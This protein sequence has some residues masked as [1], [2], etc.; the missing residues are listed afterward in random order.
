MMGSLCLKELKKSMMKHLFTYG[1]VGLAEIESVNITQT[2][3]GIIP[4]SWKVS[5][6]EEISHLRSGGTPP[7]IN[8]NYF[9]GVSHG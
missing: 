2:E 3:I 1:P 9:K 7:R 5:R 4:S 8:P 6:L